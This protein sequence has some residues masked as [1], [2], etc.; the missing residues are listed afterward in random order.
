MREL[1][2]TTRDEGEERVSGESFD[3]G[4]GYVMHL[5][6]EPYGDAFTV[7]LKYGESTVSK[8]TN[9]HSQTRA[10]RWAKRRKRDHQKAHKLLRFVDSKDTIGTGS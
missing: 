10:V 8:K 5:I 3:I 4:E 6:W 2:S 9:M 7:I 1:Q